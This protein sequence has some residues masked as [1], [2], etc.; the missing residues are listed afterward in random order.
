MPFAS[1]AFQTLSLVFLLTFSRIMHFLIVWVDLTSYNYHFFI[2]A[3]NSS[4][5][6][7]TKDKLLIAKVEAHSKFYY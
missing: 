1:S 6:I 5:K 4:I 7:K 3:D 2:F